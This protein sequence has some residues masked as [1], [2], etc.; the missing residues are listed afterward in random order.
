[1]SNPYPQWRPPQSR[2]KSS[3]LADQADDECSYTSPPHRTMGPNRRRALARYEGEDT[4]PTSEKELRGFY[5]YGWASEV[6]VICGI[7]MLDLCVRHRDSCA[8]FWTQGLSFL[9]LLNSLRESAAFFLPITKHHVPLV[10]NPLRT[11][12]DLRVARPH[13]RLMRRNASYLYW[14]RRSTR[15]HLPCT[16]SAYLSSCS[17]C[18]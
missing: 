5:M 8:D 16:L 10:L 3:S 7:G 4:R 14:G 9:S 2:S 11:F 13:R 15:R 1:M 6:F 18:S 17:H 12:R